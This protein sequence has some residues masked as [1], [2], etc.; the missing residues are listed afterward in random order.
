[1]YSRLR[2]LT[3]EE[4]HAQRIAHVLGGQVAAVA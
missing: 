3:I 1:M 4:Y 2:T